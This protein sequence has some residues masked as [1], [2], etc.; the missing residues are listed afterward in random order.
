MRNYL[1]ILN[2]TAIADFFTR[3]RAE[4]AFRRRMLSLSSDESLELYS[5][6]DGRKIASSY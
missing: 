4:N 3:G 5:I 1:L 6:P 2:G